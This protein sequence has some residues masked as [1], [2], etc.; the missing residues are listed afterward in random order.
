MP[1]DAAERDRCV[2][3]RECSSACVLFYGHEGGRNKM[4]D[5]ITGFDDL[6]NSYTS[7][8]IITMTK[9]NTVACITHGRDV[10]LHSLILL[11]Y[12]HRTDLDIDG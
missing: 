6:S 5:S 11:G 4:P 10:Q 9:S 12:L 8:S 1:R 2:R 7:K 3:K